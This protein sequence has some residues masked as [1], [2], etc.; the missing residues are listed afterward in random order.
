[1]NDLPDPQDETD[2]PSQEPTVTPEP[3]AY[4]PAR[5]HARSRI[6]AATER[7]LSNLL[8]LAVLPKVLYPAAWTTH[9]RTGKSIAAC[10]PM[11]FT[12][13]AGAASTSPAPSTSPQAPSASGSAPLVT[14]APRRC[15]AAKLPA[16]RRNSRPSNSSDHM[17]RILKRL[18]WTPQ[19]PITRATQRDE[20]AIRAWRGE[21]WPEV[22]KSRIR[23]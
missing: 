17:S 3:E 13:R 6:P 1:M 5:P 9:R 19:K 2:R 8:I 4:A 7:Q 22:K 23:G 15:A 16:Q 10:A 11:T 14:M 12:N 18:G 20:A 21:R